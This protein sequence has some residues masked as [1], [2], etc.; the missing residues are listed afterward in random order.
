MISHG[1]FELRTLA[2]VI[3]TLGIIDIRSSSTF[4]NSVNDN[5]DEIL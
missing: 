5:W 3:P 2:Y 4:S 1:K